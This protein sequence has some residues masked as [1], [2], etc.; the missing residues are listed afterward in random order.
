MTGSLL[1][2]MLMVPSNP[3][4][5]EAPPATEPCKVCVGE[6]VVKKV[7]RTVYTS[8]TKEFCVTHRSLLSLICHD[9]APECST[10]RTKT[11]LVKKIVV[12][13]KPGFKCELKAAGTV[14]TC[15]NCAPA[16]SK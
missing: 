7:S 12:E 8:T 9:D 10:P 6:A 13:E 11:V 5:V 1:M 14:G 3:P 15:D 4:T 16:V 2:L